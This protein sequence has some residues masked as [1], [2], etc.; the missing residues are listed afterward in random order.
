MRARTHTPHM[1]PGCTPLTAFV[2]SECTGL[3]ERL[4]KVDAVT[5]NSSIT[6]EVLGQDRTCFHSRRGHSA[7]QSAFR[8]LH[9]LRGL[10][11]LK[12]PQKAYNIF[13]MPVSKC[14][15]EGEA[16]AER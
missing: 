4:R 5:A 16:E 6:L 7:K 9:Q 10:Q 8:R 15:Q 14:P 12:A 1:R 11:F 2:P 3:G 13:R